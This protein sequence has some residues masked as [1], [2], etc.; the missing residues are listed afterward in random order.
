MCHGAREFRGNAEGCAAELA[1]QAGEGLPPAEIVFRVADV[2]G[3]RAD[4]GSRFIFWLWMHV[5]GDIAACVSES[6]L[7]TFHRLMAWVG[8]AGPADFTENE[9]DSLFA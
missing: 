6:E 3:A 7:F 4:S 8:T 1:N 2:L 9:L 5:A